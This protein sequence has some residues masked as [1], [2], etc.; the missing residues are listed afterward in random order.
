MKVPRDLLWLIGVV[1]AVALAVA[2][3]PYQVPLPRLSAARPGATPAATPDTFTFL[4]TG[5]RHA[6]AYTGFDRSTCFPQY[7][8]EA[9]LMDHP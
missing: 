4:C 7:F 2:W 6:K 3:T 8:A 1:S 9:G 5:S